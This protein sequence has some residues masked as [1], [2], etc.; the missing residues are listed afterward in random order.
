[1]PP[2]GN[3]EVATILI[4]A[5][6]DV[7]AKDDVR[8]NVPLYAAAANNHPS[9]VEILLAH[10]AAISPLNNNS[11]TPLAAAAGVGHVAVVEMLLAGGAGPSQRLVGGH[12]PLATA[13]ISGHV[14]VV[15]ALLAGGADPS[16]RLVG[17]RTALH[18]LAVEIPVKEWSEAC[19][20]ALHK[21]GAD[22]DAQA[23][24]GRTLLFM[25][26]E[27]GSLD[28]VYL[29]SSLGADATITDHDGVLP[30]VIALQ[31]GHEHICIALPHWN[32]V[33]RAVQMAQDEG[34]SVGVA[35]I[36]QEWVVL[37]KGDT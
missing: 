29:L 9:I 24:D 19:L 31:N 4:N 6:A 18:L 22:I 23:D 5:G 21:G 12:N 30:E 26:A 36:I 15:K 8:D 37:G 10:N 20:M 32:K 28:F 1:M 33:L 2:L 7:E 13:A 16:Q 14:A 11:F 35:K 17:G 3:V 34:I 27:A 25:A